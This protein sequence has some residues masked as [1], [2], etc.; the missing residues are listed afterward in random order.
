MIFINGAPTSHRWAS[1]H[2]VKNLWRELHDLICCEYNEFVSPSHIRF[3][4]DVSG[5]PYALFMHERQVSAPN[6]K[7]K[8]SCHRGSATAK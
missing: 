2:D 7:S 4:P 3:Q 1:L 6:R 5:G 8:R